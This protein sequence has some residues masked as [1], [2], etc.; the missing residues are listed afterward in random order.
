MNQTRA[1]PFL[2]R[3]RGGS[4]YTLNR[5]E[6]DQDSGLNDVA[7]RDIAMSHHRTTLVRQS[8]IPI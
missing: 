7:Q 4:T 8:D 1:G 2:G 3:T 6:T 5:P